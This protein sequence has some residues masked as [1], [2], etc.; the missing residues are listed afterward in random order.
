MKR[1]LS[2]ILSLAL[3]LSLCGCGQAESTPAETAEPPVVETTVAPTEETLP[4]GNRILRNCSD[5]PFNAFGTR[6]APSDI[7]YIQFLDSNE[8]IAGI[9]GND[10]SRD[11]DFSVFA[12]V[13]E[14]GEDKILYLYGKGGIIAP[15]DCSR[16]FADYTNLKN[17]SFGNSFDTSNVTNMSGMFSNCAKLEAL[18]LG[19]FDTSAVQDMS[20]MFSGCTSL[21]AVNVSS[22]DTRNVQFLNFMFYGADQITNVDISALDTGRVVDFEEFMPAGGTVNGQNWKQLFATQDASGPLY[23]DKFFTVGGQ[24]L[25][26]SIITRLAADFDI[27]YELTLI[28]GGNN[29]QTYTL[30]PVAEKAQDHPDLE[31]Q[32]VPVEGGKDIQLVN[33]ISYE[34]AF[35]EDGKVQVTTVMEIYFALMG[36]TK[37]DM[38]D[39]SPQLAIV[40]NSP[41][42]MEARLNGLVCHIMFSTDAVMFGFVPEGSIIE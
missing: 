19:C 4:A 3:L 28:K 41:T 16:M 25:V 7:T 12:C 29:G 10:V 8:I 11:N 1:A 36:K 32:P 17:I 26:E 5:S 18:D 2:L 39:N 6:Y 42:I 15:E 22:F 20:Y 13:V 37:Q 9:G 31:I 27:F 30:V 35:T 21:Q 40:S 38:I 24:Q 34:S 14:E 23:E 33:V